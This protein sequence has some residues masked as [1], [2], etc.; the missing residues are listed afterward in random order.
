[1]QRKLLHMTETTSTPTAT[2]ADLHCHSTAS[3][4]SKLG[5]S[6]ALGLP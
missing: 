2:R 1:V 4:I 6:R 5:V 3:A